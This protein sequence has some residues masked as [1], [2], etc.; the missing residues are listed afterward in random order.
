[1]REDYRIVQMIRA[2]WGGFPQFCDDL[3]VTP[4]RRKRSKNETAEQRRQRC[5]REYRAVSENTGYA[6]V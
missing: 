3:G 4:A 6:P 2:Q 5:I 1:M